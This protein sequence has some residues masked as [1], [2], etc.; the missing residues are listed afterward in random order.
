MLTNDDV[1]I[2]SLLCGINGGLRVPVAGQRSFSQ[3]TPL[4]TA[5]GITEKTVVFVIGKYARSQVR[6]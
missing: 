1:E 2:A 6:D 3:L 5:M 4:Q